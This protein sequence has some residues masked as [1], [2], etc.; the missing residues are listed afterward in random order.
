MRKLTNFFFFRKPNNWTQFIFNF[1]FKTVLTQMNEFE[2]HD[3]K[4]EKSM[5]FDG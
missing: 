2:K 4:N 3:D 5:N 1:N